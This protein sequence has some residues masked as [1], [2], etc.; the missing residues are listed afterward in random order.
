VTALHGEKLALVV[1]SF[2]PFITIM[3]T[4]IE[5]RII[6]MA[7]LTAVYGTAVTLQEV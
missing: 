4:F 5:L 2:I 6:G 7:D 1:V 3:G